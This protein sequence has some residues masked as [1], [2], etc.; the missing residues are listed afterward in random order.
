MHFVDRAAPA[1]I[2]F[3]FATRDEFITEADALAYFQV[4]SEPK[5]IEWYTTDH[6]FNDQARES[7]R[8]WLTE[9][10]SLGD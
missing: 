7:R 6:F 3:Q 9:V 8:R 2:L 10:L 4:A 5:Q 1:P